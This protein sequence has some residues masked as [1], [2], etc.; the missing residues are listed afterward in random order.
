MDERYLTPMH[1]TRW[2]ISRWIEGRWI[3][4][5]QDSYLDNPA[6]AE[7]VLRALNIPPT[8]WNLNFYFPKEEG[9]GRCPTLDLLELCNVLDP[10][11]PIFKKKN[12][13]VGV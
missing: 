8:E 6:D 2:V 7:A 1:N 11:H 5:V 4:L 10:T 12:G 9:Q 13:E 3:L